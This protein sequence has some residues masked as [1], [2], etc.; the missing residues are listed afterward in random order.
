MIEEVKKG[1]DE[2]DKEKGYTYIDPLSGL[3]IYEFHVDDLDNS[4]KKL[5][6]LEFGGFLNGRKRYEDWPII[7]ICQDKCIFKQ[8]LLVKK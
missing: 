6:H 4:H 5:K 1:N 3:T 2:F 7:M 8:Y